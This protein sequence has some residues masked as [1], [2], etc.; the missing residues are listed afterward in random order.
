MSESSFPAD[1]KRKI[2]EL[3][4]VTWQTFFLATHVL[5]LAKIQSHC[6]FLFAQSMWC[7]WCLY[8]LGCL[9]P[10][11]CLWL[12]GRLFFSFLGSLLWLLLWCYLEAQSMGKHLFVIH[13]QVESQPA[14]GLWHLAISVAATGTIVPAVAFSSVGSPCKICW[15]MPTLPEPLALPEPMPEPLAWP[16]PLALPEPL[17]TMAAINCW[18]RGIIYVWLRALLMQDRSS[19]T[20]SFSLMEAFFMVLWYC[21]LSFF[22][23]R[24]WLAE[25]LISWSMLSK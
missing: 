21:A 11:G 15:K 7:R 8:L 20:F 3:L 4:S 6:A 14:S 2:E 16:E 1:F 13:W 9:Y 19:S 17:A 22:K 5:F 23:V 24:S 25:I 10:L 18:N 12:L